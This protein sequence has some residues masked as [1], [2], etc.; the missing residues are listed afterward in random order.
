MRKSTVSWWGPKPL[1][2][3]I[4]AR[5]QVCRDVARRKANETRKS[6]TSRWQSHAGKFRYAATGLSRAHNGS[7]PVGG[8]SCTLCFHTDMQRRAPKRGLNA[9]SV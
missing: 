8:R 5:D 4:S 1:S 9:G 3:S 2:A 7:T 6:H